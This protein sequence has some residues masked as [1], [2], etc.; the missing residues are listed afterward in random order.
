M[1]A[2]KAW[3]FSAYDLWYQ[4]P[5]KYKLEKIDKLKRKDTA[6]LAKGREVH[7]II[8]KYLAKETDWLPETAVKA[9]NARATYAQFREFDD[10]I[11]EKQWGFTSGWKPTGWFSGDTWLRTVVDAGVLYEDMSAE[12]IDHKTGKKRSGYADQLELFATSVFC[13]MPSVTMVTTR[14]QFVDFEEDPVME[15]YPAKDRDSLIAKWN[16]KVEP[17]FNDTT[18][19]PRPSDKC[20]FCDWSNSKGGQC[21]F[22]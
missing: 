18:F 9:K 17:M 20:S 4:C 19:N 10:V 1:N 3:S 8:A 21:R 12:V 2:V 16:K 22:G 5:L 7:D 11:I 14:L 6:A 15:D 13:H